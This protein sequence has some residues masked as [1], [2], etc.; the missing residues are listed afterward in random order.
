MTAS[1]LCAVCGE[2]AVTFRYSVPRRDP[3]NI[4]D[5][6]WLCSAHYKE[7]EKDLEQHVEKTGGRSM[8]ATMRSLKQKKKKLW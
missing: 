8:R 6:Q 4:N 1:G 7:E 3:N 2:R 5:G